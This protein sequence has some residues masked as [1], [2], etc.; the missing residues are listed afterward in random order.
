MRRDEL[1]RVGGVCVLAFFVLGSYAVARPATESLFLQEHG[2]ARLPW[3]WIALAFGATATVALY[4]RLCS[5]WSLTKLLS[6]AL[7]F[8]G[9]LLV[10]LLALYR[11]WPAGATFL[12]YCWKDIYVVVLVEVI[13][14]IAN[15]TFRLRTARWA[16]GLFCVAGSAGGILANLGVGRLSHAIGTVNALWAVLPL[17]AAAGLVGVRFAPIWAP[18]SPAPRGAGR[19]ERGG[20]SVLTRSPYLVLMVALIGVVQIA[21]TLVDYQFNVTIE[22][23][24]PEVD[25]RT[26]AIGEVYATIDASSMILQLATG[27]ILRA[28]GVRGVLVGIP[29]LI[30]LALS[31][32]VAAPRVLTIAI[33]KVATKAFDYSLFRAAKEILYLPLPYEEKTE[34]KA[35]VDVLTYRVS[36][37]GAS[38]LLLA[39]AA[40]S[41]SVSVGLLALAMVIAWLG[42]TLVIGQRYDRQ[43][44]T[45]SEEPARTF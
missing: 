3:V 7:A 14:G 44:R 29:V 12:L 31:A 10:A 41:L 5:S 34:G 16:Y 36:K 20:L 8:S 2:S 9:A 4:Q 39:L 26:A 19:V 35:I 11:V 27:P 17:L 37:A 33:A 40:A 18:A 22:S 15:V 43:V 28:V 25:A 42:L 21:I 23:A 24:I 6:R 32:F 30:A 45:Q 38:L 13:W 1:V